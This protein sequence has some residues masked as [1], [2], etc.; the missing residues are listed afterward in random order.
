VQA[1]GYVNAGTVEFLRDDDG[2]FY[3]ME[4]NARLQVEHPVTEMVT[5]V[6]IVKEMINIA[7]GAPLSLTQEQVPLNGHSIECRIIAEDPS[8]NFM[9]APGTI[10][11]LRPPSGPGVRYDDGTYA[12]YTV[13]LYYDP[14]IAKLIVWGQNRREAISRMARA[15]DELRIDGLKTSVPFHRKLMAHQAFIDAEL[16]TG[17]LEQYPEL[18][19]ADDDPWLS[20]IA[21]IA[22]AVA[23]FRRIE[24][25][26]AR[27]GDAT[28][29]EGQRSGW[30]W[31]A[32]R[33]WGG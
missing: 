22:A 18:L 25:R 23:H 3:F 33:G 4:V 19:Q 16:H 2:L 31:S 12:G 1:A 32:R 13:P 24:E 9:P 27:G 28:T 14:M 21:V 10:R 8:R 7:A 5:G 15:L 29:Q 11:G 6:D 20:E 26:S 30:K 17:F